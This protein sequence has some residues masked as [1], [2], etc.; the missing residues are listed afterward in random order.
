[1]SANGR[2]I[3]L[4]VDADVERAPAFEIQVD[5]RAVTAHPGESVAAALLAAGVPATRRSVRR[6]EPRAYFCGMGVC[7]ECAVRVDGGR[8]ERACMLEARPGMRIE[9]EST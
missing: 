4:R 9:T 5:G 2:E 7:W 1:M 8:R 3:D 6:R